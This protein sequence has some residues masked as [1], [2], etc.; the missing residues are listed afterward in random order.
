MGLLCLENPR[1]SQESSLKLECRCFSSPV[2]NRVCPKHQVFVLC[3][4][5]DSHHIFVPPVLLFTQ[6]KTTDPYFCIDNLFYKENLSR[7]H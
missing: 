3:C 4:H 2:Y 6:F 1:R 5:D 7:Y